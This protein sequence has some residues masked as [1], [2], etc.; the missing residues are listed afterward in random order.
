MKR[1]PGT[2]GSTSGK[3][4]QGGTTK[5]GNNGGGKN[6]TTPPKITPPKAA[7]AKKCNLDNGRWF[8]NPWHPKR[9]SGYTCQTI[10]AEFNCQRNGRGGTEFLNYEWK[11]PGCNIAR[12]SPSSFLQVMRNKVMLGVGDSYST[13][14]HTA[15]RCLV[16][17]VAETRD[18]SG[19]LFRSGV[20]GKG[21]SVPQFNAT[22]LLVPSNFLVRA[23]PVGDASSRNPWKVYLNQPDMEWA[24]LLRHTNFVTFATGHW[25]TNAPA[26]LRTYILNGQPHPT[27]TPYLAMRWALSTVRQFALGT[28]YK[29][30]PMVLTHTATHYGVAFADEDP[31]QNCTVAQV[32]LNV[33]QMQFA[34]KNTDAMRARNAQVKVFEKFPRFKMIDVTRSTLYRPDGHMQSWG[35]E[36]MDCS[37]WCVPGV[38]DSWAD[39]M[40]SFMTKNIQ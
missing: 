22:F 2:G 5:Q 28:R 1:M 38:P 25:F 9:Y 33:P 14:L 19:S 30:M 16:E 8:R 3:P 36:K 26:N 20:M 24:P 29:G 21:Y 12:F 40:Y 37:H 13:N 23:Q 6:K 7:P 27:M 34:A 17:S 32:P 4:N 18:F 10:R 11:A 39:I 31:M 15:V 35:D